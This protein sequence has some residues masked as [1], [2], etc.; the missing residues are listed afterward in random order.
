M[1]RVI[2]SDVFTLTVMIRTR[3]SFHLV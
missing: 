1:A 2:D 3:P